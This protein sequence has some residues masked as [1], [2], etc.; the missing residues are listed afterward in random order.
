MT[1]LPRLFKTTKTGAT[2]ICDISYSG[3]TFTVTWGQLDGK[4]QSKD[5]ACAGTNIGRSN[6][7]SPFQQ[8]EFEALAKHK[9]K[10]DSGYSLSMETP[11]EVLLAQKVKV[12]Q[13]HKDKIEF[14]C[15]VMAKLNGV[16]AEYR[17]N[18][19]ILQLL[20]RGGLNYDL[21]PHQIPVIRDIMKKLDLTSMNGEMYDHGEYLEDITSRVKKHKEGTENLKFYVFD[22]PTAGTTDEESLILLD[23]IRDYVKENDLIHAVRPMGYEIVNSHDEI[24]AL[25]EEA[26]A[27]RCEGL[28]IRNMKNK[29]TY[30]VRSSNVFK[31][32]KAQDTERRIIGMDI[33]KNGNPT[34]IL[35][36]PEGA[37]EKHKTLRVTPK[38]TKAE[39]EQIIEDYEAKYQ[40]KWYK[41]EF[42]MYSKYNVPLKPI[43]IGLRDCD[44]DG[45]PRE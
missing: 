7:R 33:D 31:Y 17:L 8:A 23:Y 24:E 10:V 25:F 42:E 32:K 15:I 16:N 34:L 18:G 44:E 41:F 39:R 2:Q 37:E 12:Y 28:I 4:V 19:D 21:I 26:T 3:N 45:N 20:S 9:K 27:A 14:P 13:D 38:G 6:E 29:Y 1:Q 35:D 43:G 11:S 5:T 22:F 30:N 36:N 40:N